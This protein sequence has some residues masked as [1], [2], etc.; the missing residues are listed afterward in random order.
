VKRVPLIG[1]LFAIALACAACGGGA[2]HAAGSRAL[3]TPLLKQ[4]KA[5]IRRQSVIGGAAS[6]KAAEVYG[7]ASYAAIDKVWEGRGSGSV[8]SV[9]GRWYLIVLHGHFLWNGSVPPGA[10]AV[11]GNRKIGLVVWSPNARSLRQGGTGYS[12]A[13][14]VPHA[15]SALRGPAA[16]NLS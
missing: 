7:P 15:I 9:S 1:L 11:P 2:K 5:E 16:I 12:V 4:I 6:A 14:R 3:P 8:T 10:K 13:N